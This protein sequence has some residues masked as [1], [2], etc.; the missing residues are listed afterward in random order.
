MNSTFDIPTVWLS[1][2]SDEQH[3]EGICIL[4]VEGCVELAIL[5]LQSVNKKMV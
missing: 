4:D 5:V 1:K 3:I 2:Y